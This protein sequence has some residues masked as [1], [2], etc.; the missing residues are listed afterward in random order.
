MALVPVD[1]RSVATELGDAA[2][3]MRDIASDPTCTHSRQTLKALA[4]RIRLLLN[5]GDI[6]AVA[7]EIGTRDLLGWVFEFTET[8]D[9]IVEE[10]YVENPDDI[11]RLANC[12]S[13][14]SFV[15]QKTWEGERIEKIMAEAE[16]KIANIGS[17][18]G[19]D[20][21]EPTRPTRPTGKPA[22]VNERMAG[23]IMATPEAMGWNSAQW[24][25][26]LKCG[27]SSVVETATWKKLESARLQAKAERMKDRRRKPKASDSRRD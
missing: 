18:V 17:Q 19:D 21:A 9:V 20:G 3:C 27:K 22:T 4:E 15:L 7:V 1:L 26:H 14:E 24:A 2:Q 25:K 5:N 16:S 23:T 11:V 13:Y 6:N 8:M 10:P 12:Y